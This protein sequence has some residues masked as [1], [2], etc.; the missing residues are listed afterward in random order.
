MKSNLAMR[1]GITIVAA[2]LS[3]A[4]TLLAQPAAGP[5][6]IQGLDQFSIAG[7]RS[8]AM[9]GT[10]VAS[11]ND[12]SALF[13]NPA[14]LAPSVME[15]RAGGLFGATMRQQT[16][17]W[18]PMR[19]IPGLSVLFE[20]LTGTVKTP[21]SLGRA[22]LPLS[23]WSTVQRQYDDIQPNWSRNSSGTQPLSLVA[24][25]PLTLAGMSM[26]KAYQPPLQ[27]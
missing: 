23:A 19:P 21:D 18:V 10:G 13:L 9:G 22:G 25:M 11:A 1:M 4:S 17:E 2:F 20:G 15:I 7:V 27:L 12:A 26:S 3:F 6:N 16:Q 24:A 14:T 8:R 5:L